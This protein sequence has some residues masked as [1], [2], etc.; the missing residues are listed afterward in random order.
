MIMN[1]SAGTE[2]LT[3]RML[4]SLILRSTGFFL[5]VWRIYIAISNA[6]QI[7]RSSPEYLPMV[8]LSTL[9]E[10]SILMILLFLGGRITSGLIRE[11]VVMDNANKTFVAVIKSM[12]IILI[13][14]NILPLI[15][16]V[17]MAVTN[18]RYGAHFES[19]VLILLGIY[20]ATGARG[21]M[22]LIEKQKSETKPSNS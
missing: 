5:L 9:L 6:S 18:Q 8:C 22:N 11:P 15:L 21:F 2:Q 14:T 16:T 7:I 17:I 4:I 13:A 1:E 19:G 20:L 12:G 3:D 10:V